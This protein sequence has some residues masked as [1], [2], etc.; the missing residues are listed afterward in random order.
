MLFLREPQDRLGQPDQLALLV[1]LVHKVCLEL[2][3]LK[4]LRD[5]LA[6]LVLPEQRDQQEPQDLPEQRVLQDHKEPGLLVLRGQLGRLGRLDQVL[7]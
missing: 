5:Q 7:L 3:G 6:Q 2:A 1:R 4:E